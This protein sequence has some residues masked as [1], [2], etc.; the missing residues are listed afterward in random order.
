MSYT[1]TVDDIS[2]KLENYEKEY[3]YQN[4][5]MGNRIKEYALNESNYQIQVINLINQ[6]NKIKKEN[7]IISN[8]SNFVQCQYDSLKCE[9]ERIIECFNSIQ[10][11]YEE[12]RKKYKGMEEESK[13]LNNK[14][15][16]INSDLKNKENEI[17]NLKNLLNKTNINY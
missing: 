4:E 11:S 7:I 2:Q 5:S 3:M 1:E 14:F 13:I 15:N 10:K 17:Q 16:N 8:N 9:Y 6:L 12:L